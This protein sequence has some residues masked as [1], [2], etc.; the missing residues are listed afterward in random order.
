MDFDYRA[1]LVFG[2]YLLAFGG[3]FLI[4]F[5]II[6]IKLSSV[7]IEKYSEIKK[8]HPAPLYTWRW[9]SGALGKAPFNFRINNLLKVDVY[10]Y[11][12]IV[13]ALGRAICLPYDR[14]VFKHEKILFINYL[15]VEEL[16]LYDGGIFSS[17]RP[18]G[19]TTELKIFISAK[20][21][22]KIL[23]LVRNIE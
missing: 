16:P 5:K 10:P 4:V 23:A 7:F 21:I 17:L 14:Y 2:F 20:K 6:Q 22:E 19:R 11:M 13:S 9:L 15:I 12:L 18:S 1:V 3:F 8:Q